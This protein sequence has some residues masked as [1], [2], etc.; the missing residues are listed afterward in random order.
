[1]ALKHCKPIP[2][3]IGEKIYVAQKY[4]KKELC[5]H[6]S[7]GNGRGNAKVEDWQ[8]VQAVLYRLKTGCQWRELPVRQFFAVGYRWQSVYHH[9]RKWCRD[10][11]WE[12]AWRGALEKHKAGLDMSSVQ[13]DGSHTPAKRGGGAVAYQGRKKCRTTNMLFL[14]DRR[15]QPLACGDAA[16]GNHHDTH[17]LAGQVKRMLG[18][19][20]ASEIPTGG[21]FLN[22]DAG[23]DAQEFRDFLEDAEINANIRPNPRNGG[24]EGHFFD[25]LL[26]GHRFVVERTNAWLDGFKA[27]LV[28]FETSPLHW[29][30]LHWLAFA[31]ILLR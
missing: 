11:S 30:A 13:L 23:F 16:A 9:F 14:T 3:T 29:K 2:C 24:G 28:R 15:G 20:E 25:E 19:L 8:V 17:G 1:M 21:L 7:F 26:Y 5:P 10:G 18:A 4:H 27:L 6:L 12:K 22:A 31:V